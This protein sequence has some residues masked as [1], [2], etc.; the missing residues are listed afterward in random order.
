MLLK[1]D[2]AKIKSH[3]K[4]RDWKNVNPAILIRRKTGKAT[5]KMELSKKH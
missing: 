5:N 2:I 3:R 4:A 1:R